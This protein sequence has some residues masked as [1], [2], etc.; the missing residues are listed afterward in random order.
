MSIQ[1]IAW[2]SPFQSRSPDL[3]DHGRTPYCHGQHHFETHNWFGNEAPSTR[4]VWTNICHCLHCSLC[5]S[6][7]MVLLFVV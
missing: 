2:P 6:G 7:W 3:N 4:Y 5:I 1:R